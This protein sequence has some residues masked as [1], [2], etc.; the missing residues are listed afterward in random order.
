MCTPMHQILSS[1]GT[2]PSTTGALYLGLLRTH[3]QVNGIE[4]AYMI[5][6]TCYLSFAFYE[7]PSQQEASCSGGISSSHRNPR[8]HNQSSHVRD[9]G[10]CSYGID[11]L[12]ESTEALGRYLESMCAFFCHR[13]KRLINCHILITSCNVP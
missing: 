3:L 7:S 9:S 5:C 4:P 13:S 8:D 12:D 6:L 10:F 11:I 2:R 1:A